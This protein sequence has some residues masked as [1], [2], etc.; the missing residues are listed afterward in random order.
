[1]ADRLA[2]PVQVAPST[3]AR[4]KAVR[5]KNTQLE[6]TVRKAL[7]SHGLRFRIHPPVAGNPD[8][9][10]PRYKVAVWTHGC[11]WHGHECKKGQSGLQHSGQWHSK[12]SRTIERDALNLERAIATGW[13]VHVIWGCDVAAGVQALLRTLER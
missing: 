3:T 1:M 2:L 4:M 12:V 6:L 10:L 7:H 5:S 9:V 8:L 13:K 11:F